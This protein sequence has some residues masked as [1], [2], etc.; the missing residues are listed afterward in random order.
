MV[1][2]SG[3]TALVTGSGQGIGQGIAVALAKKGANVVLADISD[4]IFEVSEQIIKSATE[5]T[6]MLL[7]IDAILAAASS[8]AGTQVPAGA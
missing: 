1:D 7:R 2:L 5:T 4:S 8:S 3:K 6:A